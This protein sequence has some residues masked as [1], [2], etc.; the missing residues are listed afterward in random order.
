MNKNTLHWLNKLAEEGEI[1]SSKTGTRV[2]REI[3][4]L[5]QSGVI[6]QINSGA[7]SRYKLMDKQ[8]LIGML[9]SK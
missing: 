2:K 8:S 7:G 5:L 1:I 4:G 9:D 6:K 3:S